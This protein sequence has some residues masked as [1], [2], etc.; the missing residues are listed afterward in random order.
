MEKGLDKF[1]PTSKEIEAM[2]QAAFHEWVDKAYFVLPER[3]IKRDPL[4]HLKKQISQ[5]LDDHEKS[6]AQ[7]EEAV[8]QAINSYYKKFSS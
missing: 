1:L 8:F 5:I 6:E 3:K 2:S 4:S 7:K